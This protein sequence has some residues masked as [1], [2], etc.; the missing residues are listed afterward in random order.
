[1]NSCW[2]DE[3]NDPDYPRLR[4]NGIDTVCRSIRDSRTTKAALRA[5]IAAG[6]GVSVY[7]ASSWYPGESGRQL[8]NIVSGLL[9]NCDLGTPDKPSVCA[10]IERDDIG[11]VREFFRRW[12]VVRALRV[13]D[14][15]LEG[16][17]GGLLT[18]TDVAD[19]LV[20]VKRYFVPQCYDGAMAHGW[21]PLAMA[22]NLVAAGIPLERVVPFLDASRLS[23][24]AWW[25]GYAF[26]QGRLS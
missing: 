8:C 13:T 11:F 1:M 21:D 6:F 18:P 19:L 26:T 25:Q 15:T 14:W 9:V 7:F 2:I 10:D 20:T 4:A 3:G 16:H 12:H 23:S 22:K 24:Y 5:D 17:K